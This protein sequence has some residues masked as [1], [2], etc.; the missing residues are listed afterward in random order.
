METEKGFVHKKGQ[1][2][3]PEE[4]IAGLDRKID[5]IADA[6]AYQKVYPRF[7]KRAKRLRKAEVVG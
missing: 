4:V 2:P 5:M 1:G 3:S 6:G 7:I